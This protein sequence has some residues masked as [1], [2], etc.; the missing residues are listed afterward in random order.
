MIQH[1][2]LAIS[3]ALVVGSFG[4]SEREEPSS[5]VDRVA[6]DTPVLTS[7]ASTADIEPAPPALEP[8]PEE[9]DL[10]E[11]ES[12]TTPSTG[13]NVDLYEALPGARALAGRDP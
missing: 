12:E 13:A 7:T 2:L 1:I 10:S 8:L 5:L 3:A 11:K 6:A 4:C 9:R